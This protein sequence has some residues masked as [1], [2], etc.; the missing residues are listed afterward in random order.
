MTPSASTSVLVPF[1]WEWGPDVLLIFGSFIAAYLVASTVVLNAA[2]GNRAGWETARQQLRGVVP[3]ANVL[4]CKVLQ[5]A[6]IQ[7]TIQPDARKNLEEFVHSLDRIDSIE[8]RLGV[9]RKRGRFIG[10]AIIFAV[11]L[12]T[13]IS[14]PVLFGQAP[15]TDT[16]RGLPTMIP[17]GFTAIAY[18]LIAHTHASTW[19]TLQNQLSAIEAQL[20]SAKL[21][22]IV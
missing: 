8:R 9:L 21:E 17:L 5:I 6:A 19:S 1:L 20:R 15:L 13:V 18:Y 12:G 11:I 14:G 10:L 3:A 16:I 22:P 7:S 4:G 2:H